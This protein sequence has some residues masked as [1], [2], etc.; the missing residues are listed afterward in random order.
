MESKEPTP[1][2]SGFL[3]TA[4]E[5]RYILVLCA[6]VLLGVVARYFY[7]KSQKPSVYTPEGIEAEP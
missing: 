3:L 4:Q 1:L 6:I 2:Q 7:L 5:K